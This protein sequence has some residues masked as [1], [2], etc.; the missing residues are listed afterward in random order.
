MAKL[1]LITNETGQR[2]VPKKNKDNKMGKSSR[3]WD[4]KR[5]CHLRLLLR[6]RQI[7]Q[8]C[9]KP[10]NEPNKTGP[11][12]YRAEE[13]TFAQVS[14]LTTICSKRKIIGKL[15]TTCRSRRYPLTRTISFIFNIYIFFKLI[16]ES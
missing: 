2:W 15:T 5:V 10:R 13:Q 3:G 7:N 14:N 8:A 12:T 16:F 6:S 9:K 1:W 11:N 4:Q